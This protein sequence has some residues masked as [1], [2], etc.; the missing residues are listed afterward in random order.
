MSLYYEEPDVLFQ[1]SDVVETEQYFQE[2]KETDEWSMFNKNEV[3]MKG[4]PNAPI[5]VQEEMEGVTGGVESD[6][7]HVIKAM[8]TT[9][10]LLTY[11]G[12]DGLLTTVP[13]ADTAWT[14]VLGR[15]GVDCPAMSLLKDRKSLMEL[16]S[17]DKASFFNT[18]AK[19]FKDKAIVLKRD[20]MIRFMGSQTYCIL[21][22]ADL[23]KELQEKLEEQYPYYNFISCE[24]G[25]ELT[26]VI[27]ELNDDTLMDSIKKYLKDP[28]DWKPMLQFATSDIGL[29]AATLYPI[30][31]HDKN[32][33]MIGNGLQLVHDGGSTPDKIRDL[34]PLIMSLFS[35]CAEKMERLHNI[36][37]QNVRGCFINVAKPIVSGTAL[38]K[39]AVLYVADTI[40][41]EYPDGCTGLDIYFKLSDTIVYDESI[42]KEPYKLSE[43][44]NI[45]EMLARVLGMNIHEFDND[46]TSW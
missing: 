12:N 8:E 32:E 33:I 25:Y 17:E 11:P 34:V 40:E 26:R 21:P 37:V 31:T 41:K 4:I 28:Y 3:T 45:Q 9:K 10:M 29:R 27:Y 15:Y 1:S 14:A 39:K 22:V 30:I 43:K 19:R 7:A 42:R 24:S 36:S 35:D 38:T 5:L 20:N 2:Q 6:E 23:L 16:D 44:V 13:I 18:V 46:T